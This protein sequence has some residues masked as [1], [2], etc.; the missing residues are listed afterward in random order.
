MKWFRVSQRK[1]Q[2]VGNGSTQITT[3]QQV[4]EFTEALLWK[5]EFVV[6]IN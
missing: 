1:T 2:H 3:P 4:L 6:N 5:K